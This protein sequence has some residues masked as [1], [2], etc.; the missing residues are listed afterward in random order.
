M[1]M[2]PD[3]VVANRAFLIVED[4]KISHCTIHQYFSILPDTST[5]SISLSLTLSTR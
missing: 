4:E 3:I 1:Q 5:V 2:H